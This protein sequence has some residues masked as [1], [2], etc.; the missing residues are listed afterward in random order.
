MIMWG[1]YW[2]LSFSMAVISVIKE[3]KHISMLLLPFLFFLLHISYG[4]G[5]LVG[6]IKMPFYRKNHK[7]CEN[8]ECVKKAINNKG[9]C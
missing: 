3:K 5:T 2:L 4:I 6:L 8:I 1:L 7:E 9:D